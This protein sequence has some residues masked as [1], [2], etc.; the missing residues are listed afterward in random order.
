MKMNF[1][2]F[3][4]REEI[5]YGIDVRD[6]NNLELEKILTEEDGLKIYARNSKHE[7][8]IE[9]TDVFLSRGKG[10]EK[11]NE[12]YFFYEVD[13]NDSKYFKELIYE[14]TVSC[15]GLLHGTYYHYIF[16]FN[17]YEVEE[18]TW[19]KPKIYIDGEKYDNYISKFYNYEDEEK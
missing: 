16:S 1:P 7:I 4:E 8:R 13:V 11:K 17:D 18:I 19:E 6:I 12:K 5:K 15:Y 14:A 9:L 3:Y 2:K 10:I